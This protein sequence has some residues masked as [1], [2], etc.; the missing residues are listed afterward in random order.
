MTSSG[1]YYDKHFDNSGAEDLR[2]LTVLYYLN[3][4]WREELGGCF[5]IYNRPKNANVV[6][7]VIHGIQGIRQGEDIIYDV[8]P[9]GDRLLL[10]W[11][12]RL[13]HSVQPSQAPR[14][15][16]VNRFGVVILTTHQ[17]FS[18]PCF[19]VLFQ[20]LRIIVGH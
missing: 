8:E 10:F 1:S 14:G 4:S 17:P 20:V 2:K 3:P 13:V 15:E 7:E 19:F 9:K 6:P 12:D 11:S 5:R 18:S 16:I